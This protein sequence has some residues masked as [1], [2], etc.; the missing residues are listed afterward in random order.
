VLRYLDEVDPEAA[1]RARARYGCFEE[2]GDDPQEY[3]YAAVAGESCEDAV[4]EQLVELR[5]RAPSWWP[6]TR[7]TRPTP[8]TTSSRRR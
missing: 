3:G 7:P 4:V 1:R 6:A 8:P 5:R 2:F